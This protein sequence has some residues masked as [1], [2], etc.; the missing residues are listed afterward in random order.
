MYISIFLNVKTKYFFILL[1]VNILIEML[2]C[3]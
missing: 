1:K 3:Q 2:A